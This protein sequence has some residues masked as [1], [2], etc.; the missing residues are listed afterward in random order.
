MRDQTNCAL[1]AMVSPVGGGKEKSTCVWAGWSDV[2]GRCTWVWHA[3]PVSPYRHRGVRVAG[4][5]AWTLICLEYRRRPLI[6][7]NKTK[8][9]LKFKAKRN[10]I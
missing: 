2:W 6:G 1:V 5:D 3:A 8:I 7:L 4:I 9:G 10:K